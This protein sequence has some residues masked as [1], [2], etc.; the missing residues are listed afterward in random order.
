[1]ATRGVIAES[2]LMAA[3]PR[4]ENPNLGFRGNPDGVQGTGLVDYGVYAL[5]LHNALTHF[6][7][8]SDV[9]SYGNNDLVA[10]YLARGWPVVVWVTYQ[11]Q[12]T[13]PLLAQHNGVQFVLV[14]HEHALTAIGFDRHTLIAN[15]PYTRS[16][17]RYSWARFDR[18]WGYFGNMALAVDPCALPGD[19]KTIR[20]ASLS[21]DSLQFTWS[22]AANASSY[23][24]TVTRHINRDKTVRDA[25][26]NITQVS[27]NNPTLG[28]LYTISVQPS[29]ACG[30]TGNVARFATLIPGVL[31]GSTPTPTPGETAVPTSTPTATVSPT[32]TAG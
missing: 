25:N 19:V 14:P 15:D 6:G 18:S 32:S 10:S 3:M 26:V 7:Y 1:M 2:Q 20:V 29:N 4:N 21:V 11:L 31:P 9:I 23:H 16:R 28:A 8:H 12:R 22:A 30:D 17:V 13:Q 24:V 27:I 5:P